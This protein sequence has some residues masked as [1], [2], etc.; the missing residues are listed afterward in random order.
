MGHIMRDC[1]SKH[2]YVANDDGRY[3]LV[4]VMK[5]MNLCMLFLSTWFHKLYFEQIPVA[6]VVDF[7][8]GCSVMFAVNLH[9]EGDAVY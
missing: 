9:L 7:Q 3:M 6:M 4:L 5:R 8:F 1:P 2:A